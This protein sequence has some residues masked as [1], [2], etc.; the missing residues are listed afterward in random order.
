MGVGQEGRVC[1][2]SVMVMPLE[3]VAGWVGRGGRGC[4][5]GMMSSTRAAGMFG[6][7][8]GCHMC[9]TQTTAP[10]L[11]STTKE[12]AAAGLGVV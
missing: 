1:C 11:L 2:E 6:L 12:E 4:L 7:R 3:S 8:I 9:M 10:T 5:V